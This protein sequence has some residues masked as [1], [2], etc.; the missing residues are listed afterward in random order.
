MLDT[1]AD[2]GFYSV[3]TSNAFGIGL[4][5]R[6]R[7]WAAVSLPLEPGFVL[8]RTLSFYPPER[9]SSRSNHPELTPIFA[10]VIYRAAW[11]ACR[12]A[13]ETPFS[14]A[15]DPGNAD[16]NPFYEDGTPIAFH[17]V[18]RRLNV[19]RLRR[20]PPFATPV[21]CSL[22]RPCKTPAPVPTH[23]PLTG[24]ITSH[25]QRH[26]SIP[27]FPV[28]YAHLD[29]AARGRHTSGGFRR[30]M[31]HR[32]AAVYRRNSFGFPPA[33][34]TPRSLSSPT[35]SNPR[36][37]RTTTSFR[38][39]RACSAGNL[40]GCG[41]PT[42]YANNTARQAAN[43]RRAHHKCSVGGCPC[44]IDFSRT[45]VALTTPSGITTSINFLL[46]V[47]AISAFHWAISA[48]Q[49]PIQAPRT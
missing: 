42:N 3:A 46:P 7:R 40:S 39:P 10:P 23:F 24:P 9:P 29:P 5:C 41:S 37:S 33:P 25:P 30:K 13:D 4:P 14:T 15:S 47:W 34:A 43:G 44:L 45:A 1:G 2:S 22:Q 27:N 31:G 26:L 49:L 17:T 21:L 8:G 11:G 36:S 35:S 16:G 28:R 19:G 18:V 6:F 20:F 48:F 32:P 38:P 12:A